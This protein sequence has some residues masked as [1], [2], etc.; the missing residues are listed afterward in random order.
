MGSDELGTIDTGSELEDNGYDEDSRE[1]ALPKSSKVL[2]NVNE[3]MTFCCS[4][5]LQC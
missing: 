3:V 1:M 4:N 2:E 5:R